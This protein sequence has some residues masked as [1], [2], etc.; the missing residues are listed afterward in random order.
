MRVRLLTARV[1]A[2]IDQQN[3]DVIEVTDS[4]GR[5]LIEIGAA[6]PCEQAVEQ[7]TRRRSFE[8][9]ARRIKR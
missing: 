6:R 1:G 4:E 8:A 3:G 2:G 9:A 7:A 5:R